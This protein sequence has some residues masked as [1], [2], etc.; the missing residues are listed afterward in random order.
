M[1][2]SKKGLYIQPLK[3][4]KYRLVDPLFIVN[5][6]SMFLEVNIVEVV[7]IHVLYIKH[8]DIGFILAGPYL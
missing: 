5:H 3:P 6:I 2:S 7:Y 4:P 1:G 8:C